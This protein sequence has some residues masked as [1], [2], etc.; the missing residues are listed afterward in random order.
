MI[1]FN[2]YNEDDLKQ[3]NIITAG[4]QRAQLGQFLVD[5]L[6]YFKCINF[7][8]V[9]EDDPTSKERDNWANTTFVHNIEYV[10]ESEATTIKQLVADY[11]KLI[12]ALADSGL[13]ARASDSNATK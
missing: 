13:M 8:T 7:G 2:K 10:P 4:T 12:K 3:L 9:I 11:N 5:V 6:H 1:D